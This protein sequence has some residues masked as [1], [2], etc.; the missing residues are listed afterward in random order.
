VL[1]SRSSNTTRQGVGY[2]GDPLHARVAVIEV[3]GGDTI[4]V[5]PSIIINNTYRTVAKPADV[6]PPGLISPKGRWAEATT[7]TTVTAI[8][9][10]LNTTIPVTTTIPATTTYTTTV[11]VTET[12]QTTTYTITIATTI[13]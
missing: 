3:A 7:L 10:T 8:A 9:T 6:N 13:T 12:T 2:H 1:T 5:A 11:P 4:H